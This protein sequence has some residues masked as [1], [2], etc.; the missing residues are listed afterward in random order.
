MLGPTLLERGV[1]SAR[2]IVVDVDSGAF[3]TGRNTE[4]ATDRFKLN[5]SECM[6]LARTGFKYFAGLNIPLLTQAPRH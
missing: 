4:E 1:L 6:W 2:Y 5:A 3:V